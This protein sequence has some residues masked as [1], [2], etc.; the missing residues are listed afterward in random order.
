MKVE[1]QS[2]KGLRTVL[3]VF[4]DKKV[5]Q[6]KMDERLN[7]LQKEVSLKGFRPGKVPPSVIKGQFGKS[8]Y[9][10]VIDKILRDTSTKAIEEK[11]IKVA[12]QPKIDLKAFGEGKDLNYELQI[13]SLPDIKLKNF[14]NYKAIEY[15][16]KIEEK[17]ITDKLIEISNH[18]KQFKDKKEGEKAKIGDQVVFDYSAKVDGNKFEGSEGKGVQLELG[19]DLFLKGFDEQLVG[20]KKNDLKNLNAT[21]PANHPKKELANK[22]SIF[23]CKIL[24][25][26]EIKENKIDDNFAK[27]MGAK[28]LNDLKKL[29]ENQI[30]SQYSQ[31][32]NAITKKRILDQIEK[33]HDLKLP[34]NL[35]D[36][37]ILSMTKNLKEEE[38]EKHKVNNEK[39]AKSRIKLGLLLNEYGEKNN[40]KVSDDEVKAEIQKQIKGMPG[41]EKMVLEYYQKNPGASQSLKG[42]IYEEKIISLIKSKIKL[43]IKNI[44]TKE[45]EKIIS[46]FNKPNLDQ[47]SKEKTKST[48]NNKPK[49]KKISKK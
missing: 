25:V 23:E 47:R 29:I 19:K 1:I 7:E 49:S 44:D 31:A 12:G 28:D 42:S 30:S 41:Q 11:K 18:N 35:I 45:A 22:K 26:K 3:S 34:Q 48:D 5:I 38:R 32:L 14:D 37:E 17:I 40:L 27:I 46:Q 39:V 21:L 20:V 15:K 8:I 16:V 6:K 24:N 33:N 2:K 9:G 43:E 4:V 36:Q 13:D 10:E